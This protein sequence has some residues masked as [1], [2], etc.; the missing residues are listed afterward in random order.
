MSLLWGKAKVPYRG[1]KQSFR[2]LGPI[3]IGNLRKLKFSEVLYYI[4]RG[5]GFAANRGV[6][7]KI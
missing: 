7:V 5:G 4:E 2:P 3:I 6:K 1:K